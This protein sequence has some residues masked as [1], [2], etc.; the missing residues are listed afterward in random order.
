ME[1]PVEAFDLGRMF[2]GDEPFL[3]LLEIALRTTII[4]AYTF[5]L[6]RWVGSRS[7]AQLSLVEFL[8]V[9]ALGSAVGD[10]MFYADV[11]LVHA[12][13]VITVVI[14][15]DKAL[16]YLVARSATVEDLIEGKTVEIM[17]DGVIL[18]SAL[19]AQNFGHDELFE[20]LRLKGV[21]HLGQVRAAYLETNG[22]VSVFKR[23]EE[24]PGLAIVPPWDVEQPRQIKAGSSVPEE[25]LLACERCGEIQE[26]TGSTTVGACP[27]CSCDIWHLA[28]VP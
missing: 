7:I 5:V 8:L 26:F 27:N 23:D 3:F 25:V 11:P 19:E 14:L 9:I 2:F 21:E 15:L 18:C 1:Q 4:Y 6:I 17:G 13:L 24:R 22:A 16:T 20:Q 10:A 28:K 12:I